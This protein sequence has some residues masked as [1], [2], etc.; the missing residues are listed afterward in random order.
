MTPVVLRYT[1]LRLLIFAVFLLALTW[2]GVP[3]LWALVFAALFSAVTSFFMLRRQRIEMAQRVE[4]TVQRRSAQR[5]Q[6]IAAQRTDED[7]EDDEI[8]PA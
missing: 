8:G 7:D 5:Q 6:R 3:G 2:L 4:R 1:V